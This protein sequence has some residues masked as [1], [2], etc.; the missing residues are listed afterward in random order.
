MYRS[1]A[2]AR[3]C[4]VGFIASG[5]GFQWVPVPVMSFHAWMAG[6]EWYI[7]YVALSRLG[8]PLASCLRGLVRGMFTPGYSCHCGPSTKDGIDFL[9]RPYCTNTTLGTCCGHISASKRP[10][11]HGPRGP[12]ATI[13]TTKAAMPGQGHDQSHELRDLRWT[14]LLA[15]KPQLLVAPWR[16]V[17]SHNGWGEPEQIRA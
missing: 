13:L 12:G 16:S 17:V 3:R 8:V 14:Q 10:L 11:G 9:K 2:G 15:L 6:C 5:S 1:D 7:L 4:L